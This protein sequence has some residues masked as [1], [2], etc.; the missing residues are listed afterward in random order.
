MLRSLEEEGVNVERCE[1]RIASSSGRGFVV[2]AHDGAIISVV[3]PGAN[4][5]WSSSSKSEEEAGALVG[6]SI[7][8]EKKMF[9]EEDFDCVLLQREIPSSVNRR[10][11]EAARSRGVPVFLD[12]GGSDEDLDFTVDW[13]TPNRQ[14]LDAVVGGGGRD[15]DDDDSVEEKASKLRDRGV[16]RNVLVTLGSR[17]AIAVLEGGH[18][19]AVAAV[20]APDGVVDETAAGDSFRAAFALELCE[21][22][23]R[24]SERKKSFFFSPSSSKRRR[25]SA[26][27]VF[28]NKADVEAAL[29]VAACAGAIAVGTAGALPSLP[30]KAAVETLMTTLR[31]GGGGDSFFPWEFASRLNS[32]KARRDLVVVVAK[33][34]D[35]QKESEEKTSNS[36]LGWI[37][38]QGE[39]QGLGLVDLNYPQHLTDETDEAE[40][41][42][43]L[44]EAKLRCGAVCLRFPEA[45]FGKGAFTHPDPA[46]RAEAVELCVKAGE[47]ARRLGADEVVVWPQFDGYD[48]PL[49]CDYAQLWDRTVDCFQ[50]VCDA[51]AAGGGGDTTSA[52][53]AAVIKVSLEFKPTDEK[54]RFFAVPSAGAACLLAKAVDRPNF[55]LTIDVGHCLAAGENPAQSV[56]MAAQHS[57]LF[58]VQLNDWSRFG[59]EDGLVF[60]SNHHLAALDVVLA[61]IDADFQGHCYF[62]TFP[63]MEDPVR[64][65]QLNIRQ[66][67]KLYGLAHRLRQQQGLKKG[68]E[69]GKWGKKKEKNTNL[70]DPLRQRHDAI[71]VLELLEKHSFWD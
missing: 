6:E 51:L 42:A 55:G 61:L 35:D 57:K 21:K 44:R 52:E 9:D 58:G 54:T 23:R 13:F 8:F 48:Y 25:T 67:K 16:A 64:E 27:A 18:V 40:V 29:E 63:R 33:D 22:R 46:V 62:D 30:S 45:R 5:N 43:A 65:A 26:A 59:T 71:G 31:G 4:G 17:G 28:P 56:S 2:V 37:A 60:G 34:D 15:D 53:E 50:R 20:E 24:R 14:E 3:V 10:F 7:S 66:V 32:M 12:A 19:C 39:I 47:W 70:L 38:R 11:A 41:K 68:E 69:K 49:Q 1:R 36:L